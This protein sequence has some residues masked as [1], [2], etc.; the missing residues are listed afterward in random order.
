MN[1][2]Y[3]R[4]KIRGVRDAWNKQYPNDDFIF[5]DKSTAGPKRKALAALD[6]ET[7]SPADIDAALGNTSWA[8]LTCDECDGDFPSIVRI[9]GEPDYDARWQDLCGECLKEALAMLA[10]AEPKP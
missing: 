3:R 10:S 9:G 4:D 6:L 1:I 2:I 5:H 7:C 8:S